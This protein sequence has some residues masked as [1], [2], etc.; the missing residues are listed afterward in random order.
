[1]SYEMPNKITINIKG[2]PQKITNFLKD[3]QNNLFQFGDIKEIKIEEPS[4]DIAILGF[5][6]SWELSEYFLKQFVAE[7]QLDFKAKCEK[8]I[9]GKILRTKFQWTVKDHLNEEKKIWAE[10]ILN[11]GYSSFNNNRNYSPELILEMQKAIIDV[12]DPD[13]DLRTEKNFKM[14]ITNILDFTGSLKFSDIPQSSICH[15]CSPRLRWFALE[16]PKSQ[17]TAGIEQFDM[18]L[19][20]DEFEVHQITS[21]LPI[22]LKESVKESL[23]KTY[24][25]TSAYSILSKVTKEKLKKQLLKQEQRLKKSCIKMRI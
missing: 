3:V 19:P 4:P 25:K 17:L 24:K 9:G 7:Y 22:K 11:K 2:A 21:K 5:K 12:L 23:T 13:L 16:L 10:K 1:M 15:N 20:E 14:A 18:T 6:E 8:E